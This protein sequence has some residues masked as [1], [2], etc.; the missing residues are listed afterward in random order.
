[1]SLVESD[2]DYLSDD[3]VNS[4]VS[5]DTP[6]N[7]SILKIAQDKDFNPDQIKRLVESANTKT[8]LKMFKNPDNK[9]KNI[10]FPVADSKDILSNFYGDC[11]SGGSS[12]SSP[13]KVTITS[14][15][16]DKGGDAISDFCDM[17]DMMRS[18]RHGDMP[19]FPSELMVDDSPSESRPVKRVVILRMKK[20]ASELKD[21]IFEKEHDY[22][23]GLEK[24]CSEFKKYYGPDFGEFEKEASL[25]HGE[26]IQPV[27]EDIR[28]M[29][30]YK[31]D[32]LPLEKIA[33]VVVEDNPLH[34]VLGN[35]LESKLEQVKYAKAIS[36]T[37]SKLKA[38]TA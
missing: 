8:F 25:I 13:K 21:R 37:N 38:L 6:L 22:V 14:I 18:S 26:V 19:S 36:L 15:T 16:V 32:P 12:S 28:A 4:Y 9:G 29:I 31:Q 34:D 17:P 3:V 2:Y 27:L 20:V 7:D 33:S 35:M 23:D 11:G 1:M 5:N 24:L 30:N 10:E